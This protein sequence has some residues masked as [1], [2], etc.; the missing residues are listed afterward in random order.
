MNKDFALFFK[1]LVDFYCTEINFP[2]LLID[3]Q[4]KDGNF[5]NQVVSTEMHAVK[6]KCLWKNSALLSRNFGCQVIEQKNT[7][8]QF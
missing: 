2:R 1:I 6:R 4:P 5:R 7:L 8:S 3:C